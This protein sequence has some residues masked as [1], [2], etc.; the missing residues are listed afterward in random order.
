MSPG[1]SSRRMAM[2]R[3][4]FVV[5]VV[6]LALTWPAAARDA[7]VLWE[8]KEGQTSG[9]FKDTWTLVGSYE[10][11]RGCRAMLNEILSGFRRRDIATVSAD[12]VIVKDPVGWQLTYTCLRGGVHPR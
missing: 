11:E 7:W 4:L 6:L 2:M 1:Y 5:L 10:S 9:Q 3:A 12:T 8:K